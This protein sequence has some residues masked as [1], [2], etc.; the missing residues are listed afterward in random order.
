MIKL[1][2]PACCLLLLACATGNSDTTNA[3]KQIRTIT[4]ENMSSTN[5]FYDL[6]IRSLDDS[7]IINMSD[8]KGKKLL[9]VNVASKCGFTPQYEGLQKLYEANKDNLEILGVPCNQFMFQEPGGKDA[10]A[11]F[12]STKY[13][14]TFPLSE[15]VKVKGPTKH[16]LYKWLTSKKKNGHS[17]NSVSWNFN[18]FLI[19][20]NGEL[21]AHFGSKVEPTSE[22]IRSLL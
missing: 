6:S 14:V 21:L 3:E 9:I 15:K 4:E 10:I 18:K 13:G 7:K 11:K 19:S 20:E 17:D 2:L 8:Y 22:E 16:A 12:C 1:F 5:N